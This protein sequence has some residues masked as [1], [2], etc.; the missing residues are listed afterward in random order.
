MSIRLRW[1]L[2][3]EAVGPPMEVILALFVFPPCPAFSSAPASSCSWTPLY[4]HLLFA[5]DLTYLVP[6]HFTDPISLSSAL[7]L[8][9]P[10]DDL[11]HRCTRIP[12][13]NNAP[14]TLRIYALVVSLHFTALITPKPRLA[15]PCHNLNPNEHVT[16]QQRH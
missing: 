6:S 13:Q 8:P 11:V 5:F 16:F 9:F 4:Y 15:C 1:L 3:H 2:V 7:R 12:T 14:T 10:Y